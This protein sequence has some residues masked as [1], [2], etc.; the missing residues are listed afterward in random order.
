MNK[1]GSNFVLRVEVS[2]SEN[3]IIT[4]APNVSVANDAGLCIATVSLISATATDN[5][6]G[7]T[8]SNDHPSATYPVGT[9]V[10]TWTAIDACGNF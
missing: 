4:C 8:V 3:P 2:D 5:C 9:T 7:V 6:L 1:T 10:V